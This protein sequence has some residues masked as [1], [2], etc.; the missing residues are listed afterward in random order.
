M[1]PA[2]LDALVDAERPAQAPTTRI[3]SMAEWAQAQA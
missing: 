3:V 1:T 2:Q